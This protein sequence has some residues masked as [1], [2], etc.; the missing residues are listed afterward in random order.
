MR[1]S[2]VGL[3]TQRGQQMTPG[4]A[5]TLAIDV[6]VGEQTMRFDALWNG[7]IGK[8]EQFTQPASGLDV[9]AHEKEL[10]ALRQQTV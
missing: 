8:G 3:Q 10:P 2:A 6:N 1:L 5:I 4:L 7:H 9:A